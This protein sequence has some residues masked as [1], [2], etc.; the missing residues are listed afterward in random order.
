MWMLRFAQHDKGSVIPNASEE[1][2]VWDASLR[3]RS[4]QHDG[5]SQ[6]DE[7]E[8][9]IANAF[10]CHSERS[11]ESIV[12]ASLRLCSVQHDRR[13]CFEQTFRKGLL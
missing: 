5:A 2:S 1:S 3:L 11:E 13:L 8:D 7:T 6:H 12:D 10:F 9:V 4:V